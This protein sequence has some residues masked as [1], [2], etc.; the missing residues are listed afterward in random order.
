LVVRQNEENEVS[1]EQAEQPDMGLVYKNSVLKQVRRNLQSGSDKFGKWRKLKLAIDAVNLGPR[2]DLVM[3]EHSRRGVES[4]VIVGYR[5]TMGERPSVR[6]TPRLAMRINEKSDDGCP[7][8]PIVINEVVS[9]I[10]EFRA[11]VESAGDDTVAIYVDGREDLREELAAMIKMMSALTPGAPVQINGETVQGGIMER[12]SELSEQLPSHPAGVP[13][14]IFHPEIALGW[15]GEWHID[16]RYEEDPRLLLRFASSQSWRATTDAISSASRSTDP[17]LIGVASPRADQYRAR[18]ATDLAEL[19]RSLTAGSFSPALQSLLPGLFKADEEDR[20]ILI[21][22]WKGTSLVALVSGT[23]GA[24]VKVATPELWHIGVSFIPS[25]A[26]VTGDEN[27]TI[28][29]LAGAALRETIRADILS[30]AATALQQTKE[31]VVDVGAMLMSGATPAKRLSLQ[32][33]IHDALDLIRTSLPSGARL[34][35][36]RIAEG[37]GAA[38]Q[39]AMNAVGVSRNAIPANE[40]RS[41][42]SFSRLNAGYEPPPPKYD[43]SVDVFFET[44]FAKKHHLE[45]WVGQVGRLLGLPGFA[46]ILN[47]II[48]AATANP[49][50]FVAKN[51]K[52][53]AEG[54]SIPKKDQQIVD[55]IKADLS[56]LA[57][58]P[59]HPAWLPLVL[60]ALYYSAKHMA[61]EEKLMRENV[62]TESMM[63]FIPVVGALE[64]GDAKSL[65]ASMWGWKEAFREGVSEHISTR[66]CEIFV[67]ASGAGDWPDHRTM[68]DWE[69]MNEIFAIP[70]DRDDDY[71]DEDSI[72]SRDKVRWMGISGEDVVFLTGADLDRNLVFWHQAI[73]RMSL[74]GPDILKVLPTLVSP[75]RGIG[76]ASPTMVRSAVV[77]GSGAD[78]RSVVPRAGAIITRGYE[79]DA[80]GINYTIAIERILET[81]SMNPQTLSTQL[82]AAIISH[83]QGDVRGLRFAYIDDDENAETEEVLKIAVKSKLQWE[84]ARTEIVGGLELLAESEQMD[85]QGGR[86]IIVV[87]G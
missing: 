64:R 46:E 25:L 39:A 29:E 47:D 4:I 48:G 18:P 87:N 85:Q 80:S 68:P 52:S 51:W 56:D 26:I 78:P 3:I 28:I 23:K 42:L 33:F 82:A 38:Q 5:E 21:P 49:L 67:A 50:G 10:G 44:A 6:I 22:I 13:D 77:V 31:L 73:S 1:M 41:P 84:Q 12:L 53:F 34:G 59:R 63:N 32:R 45:V 9:R 8:W 79:R 86:A 75:D 19:Q 24:D 16:D 7:G 14:H 54:R 72:L 40:D 76:A 60:F 30:I 71:L 55:Q 65:A 70:I 83:V 2:N 11:A 43:P 81:P 58:R 20:G 57:H 66:V 69:K 17:V 36:E 61:N 35:V 74:I 27:P 62:W 15:D 37:G